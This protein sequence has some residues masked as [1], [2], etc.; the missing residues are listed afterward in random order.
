MV[1]AALRHTTES[2][3]DVA[4]GAAQVD[5]DALNFLRFTVWQTLNPDGYK[6]KRWKRQTT[7]KI[8]L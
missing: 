5:L 3:V 7:E 6:Q 8:K 4:T 2:R 1:S